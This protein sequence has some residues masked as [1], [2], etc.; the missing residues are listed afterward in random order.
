MIEKIKMTKEGLQKQKERL[1]ELKK[2]YNEN[3][4][5]M[6]SA[7]KNSSG[8][9][10]HDN[11]EFEFLLSQEKLLVSQINRLALQIQNTE[12]IEMEEMDD[13]RININ[14]KVHINM[15]FA[16]DDE[17]EMVVQLVGEDISG[18][19]EQVSI[20]SPLGKAIYGEKIGE[21]VSY[22]VNNNKIHVNLL[23]KVKSKGKTM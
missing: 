8:D 11:A 10:A 16:K 4:L 3:E 2:K 9:G 19:E 7:F 12:I 13:D 14:D 6:T 20:N 1:E 17:E 22:E 18:V 23:R 21:T 5:A 15:I